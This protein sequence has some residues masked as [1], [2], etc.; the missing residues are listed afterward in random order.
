[1]RWNQINLH[2]T[3]LAGVSTVTLQ[4]WLATAQQAMAD[5]MTGNKPVVVQYSQ[6]GSS[7]KSVTYQKTDMQQLTMWISQLQIQLGITRGRQPVR[8]Y[9]RGR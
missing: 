3:S 4:A 8:P 9:F 5:L 6:G 7:Q 2:K 1:M